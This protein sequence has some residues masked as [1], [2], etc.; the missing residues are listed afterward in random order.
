MH[1]LNYGMQ[2]PASAFPISHLTFLLSEYAGEINLGLVLKRLF[3]QLFIF[4]FPLRLSRD[5]SGPCI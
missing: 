1:Q 3:L 2:Y 5:Q 4:N